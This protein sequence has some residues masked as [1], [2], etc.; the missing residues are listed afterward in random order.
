MG[1]SRQE[2]WSGCHCLL[3]GIFPTQGSNPCLLH[4]QEDSIPLSHQRSPFSDIPKLNPGFL[5][6][7]RTLSPQ[8]M[9]R[10]HL[11]SL[12]APE[13]PLATVQ[14]APRSGSDG[15]DPGSPAA[16]AADSLLR[17]LQA[18]V[19]PRA[20]S[21]LWEIIWSHITF[22]LHFLPASAALWVEGHFQESSVQ[23]SCLFLGPS[24]EPNVKFLPRGDTIKMTSQVALNSVL[25][26]RQISV[27]EFL[28]EKEPEGVNWR[29]GKTR[30][31]D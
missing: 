24:L 2:Y 1:F 6:S 29:L 25:L 31:K 18:G 21:E 23:P 15:P 9:L 16:L 22:Y 17:G 7:P 8:A 5:L 12:L 30:L 11:V 28:S 14:I 27:R 20:C 3:Q 4:W 26:T 10:L 19:S 13:W